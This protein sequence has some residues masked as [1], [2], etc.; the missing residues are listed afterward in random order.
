VLFRSCLSGQSGVQPKHDVVCPLRDA[1]V[2]LADEIADFPE[3]C[4]RADRMSVYS[5]ST[6]PLNLA[7]QSEY[8]GSY[9][10]LAAEAVKGAA[11]FSNGKGRGGSFA[12]TQA[13]TRP[14]GI[15]TVL[16]DI[17]GV[18]VDSPVRLVAEYEQELGLQGYAL[19]I[20]LAKSKAFRKLERGLISK[21]TF[22]SEF[23]GEW[24][25]SQNP[26]DTVQP[27]KPDIDELLKRI[28]QKP[29][30]RSHYLRAIKV[31]KSHGLKVGIITNNF[32][33]PN[34][35]KLISILQ[36]LT[37]DVIESWV[38]KLR[39]PD[40]VIFQLACSRLDVSPSECLFVDD[41]EINVKAAQSLGMQV[42]RV[43]GSDRDGWQGLEDVGGVVGV[44]LV[45]AVKNI[46]SSL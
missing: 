35:G 46:Q 43:R 4:L 17:G 27:N 2:K 34:G 21:E 30:V 25:Q 37:D 40:P 18:L 19:N 8:A 23:D 1:A 31:L 42:V 26:Q 3:A 20:A 7:L 10:V 12:P 9:H 38:V 28:G 24:T 41:L 29:R 44:D 5:N 14:P 16:F 15:T 33:D 6:L 39:K 45:T 36:S 11:A 32:K 22:V 13:P